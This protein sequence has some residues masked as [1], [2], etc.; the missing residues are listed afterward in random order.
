MATE[1]NA[2]IMLKLTCAGYYDVYAATENLK[3][4]N[5]HLLLCEDKLICI[6]LST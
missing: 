2:E 3:F 1:L 4:S 6:F 5:T